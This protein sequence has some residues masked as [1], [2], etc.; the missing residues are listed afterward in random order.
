MKNL[1]IRTALIY[2]ISIHTVSVSA[3]LVK[4]KINKFSNETALAISNFAKIILKDT[5][6]MIFY[7]FF[8]PKVYIF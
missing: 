1:F 3:E 8:E 7:L 6:I 5:V 4:N 2:I